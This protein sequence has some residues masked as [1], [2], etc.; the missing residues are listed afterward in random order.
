MDGIADR[1]VNRALKERFA[2]IQGSYERIRDGLAEMQQRMAT[3]TVTRTSPDEQVTVTVDARGRLVSLAL[4]PK[5]MRQFTNEQL[6]SLILGATNEAAAEATERVA[7]LMEQL[8]PGSA[9]ATFVR[10]GSYDD[11]LRRTD[12]AEGWRPPTERGGDV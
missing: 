5:A 4:T 1:D 10:S 2:Q 7:A 6:A 12:E 3:L 11:L 9:A 8:S